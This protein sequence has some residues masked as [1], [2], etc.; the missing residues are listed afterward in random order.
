MPTEEVKSGTWYR[1]YGNCNTAES[2]S[3]KKSPKISKIDRGK[4]KLRNNHLFL[5]PKSGRNEKTRHKLRFFVEGH[6]LSFTISMISNVV[7][8]AII[9]L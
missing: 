8:Y 7:N 6:I 9:M 2:L 5:L 3:K 1:T 4:K